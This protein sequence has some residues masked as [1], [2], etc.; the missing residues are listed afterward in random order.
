M[1]TVRFISRDKNLFFNTLK[2]RV[3]AHFQ[4]RGIS[5]Y[6]NHKMIIKTIILLLMYILPFIALSIFN[7]SFWGHM[8]LWTL[9]GI[10]LAG[11]GMSVMHDANH[12]AYSK[13]A[14]VNRWVSYSLNLLGASIH[15]WKLQHNVL[16]HTYTNIS[17]LDHD[18]D[19]KIVFRFSP[20]GRPSYFHRF[21]FIYAF[22]FYGIMSLYWITIKDFAQFVRY[23]HLKVN[24]KSTAENVL[25]FIKIV[26]LKVIYFS[27][28]I[29]F[30]LYMGAAVST[31][32]AGFV[33]MHFVA[34]IILTVI[35]QMAHTVEETSHPLP[36]PAGN[37]END[38]AIHQMNTTMNFARHNKWLSW[39]VG[40][41]NFQ[42]EHHLFSKVCHVHYPEIAPIVKQTAEEFG[43]PYLEKQTFWQAFRSHL[44]ALQQFGR[45]PSLDDAI[46]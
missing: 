1:Q 43:V 21:Q 32:V 7:P 27:I 33:L 20:H 3:D 41:L 4:E 29:G 25:I 17:K 11:I 18:I 15:N 9:T 6:A 36:C 40:G 2:S 34:G 30:P 26:L 23:I 13:N 5:S 31:V 46:G 35:F 8:I 28:I 19:D 44:G 38:W 22:F 45:M 24:Q 10:A 39:Y 12:G 37:I 16:H 42:V 14:N